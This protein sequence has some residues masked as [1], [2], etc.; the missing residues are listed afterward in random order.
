MA[1]ISDA[2]PAMADSQKVQKEV[3]DNG[4]PHNSEDPLT[5]VSSSNIPKGEKSQDGDQG[6]LHNGEGKA[7]GLSKS[8]G[9]EV[10]NAPDEEAKQKRPSKA[11][12]IWGKI[13]LDKVTVLMMLKGSIAPTIAVAFYQADSVSCR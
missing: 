1:D 10:G 9:L 2:F 5:G 11:K 6:A 4:A 12:E 7:D 3:K 8:I 13:G